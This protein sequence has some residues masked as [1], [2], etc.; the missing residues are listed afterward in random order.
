MQ[1]GKAKFFKNERNFDT[2][3]AKE[4][5]QISIQSLVDLRK[6]VISELCSSSKK[7]PECGVT[8]HDIRC[9]N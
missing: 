5:V 1:F 8:C 2:P 9:D 4:N 3:R 7:L 6:L